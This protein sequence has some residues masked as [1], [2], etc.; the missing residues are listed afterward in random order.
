M[1]QLTLTAKTLPLI[2]TQTLFIKKTIKHK[3]KQR[4]AVML[5]LPTSVS[6]FGPKKT[7]KNKEENPQK[8]RFPC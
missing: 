5:S 2:K 8:Q 3:T 1:Q 4:K 6:C 7:Q